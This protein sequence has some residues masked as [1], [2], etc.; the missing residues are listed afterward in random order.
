MRDLPIILCGLAAFLALATLPF[1]YNAMAKT[2]G[3][4]DLERPAAA[5]QCVLPTAEMRR[6]HM[7]MLIEWRDRRVRDGIRTQPGAGGQ[8]YEISLT[9]TCLEQC[10][11][12][13]AEFCDRCHAYVGLQGPDCFGCHNAP[14]D[15]ASQVT[16]HRA[17]ET[18]C[19]TTAGTG[20]REG[21][22]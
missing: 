20:R 3:R 12:N 13:K 10:H 22:K 8:V 4:V 2:S 6:S 14:L 17:G 16:A 11:R 15:T 18:A 7:A 19:P 9:H 5:K 1:W 21:A